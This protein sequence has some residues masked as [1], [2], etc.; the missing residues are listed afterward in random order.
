MFRCFLTGLFA[1]FVL[2]SNSSMNAGELK[3]KQR[4]HISIIGNTLPERMQHD[5]W[6]ETLIHNRFPEKQLTIR[7][8]AFSGDTLSIRLRSAGFGS[9]DEWLTNTKTDIVFAFFGFN[10]SFNGS[11][12]L[13][14]FQKELDEF[15]SHTLGQKYNGVSAPQLVLISPIAHEQLDDPSL[16]DAKINNR[17]LKLYTAAM[18]EIAVKREIPFVDL[19]SHSQ[20]AYR[21]SDKPLTINGVHLTSAGNQILAPKIDAALFGERTETIGWPVL[22]PLRQSVLDKN[23]FWF[24]RYRTTDGYSAYGGRSYLK[25]VEG[26]TNREV[27]M[28]ELQVLDEMTANR[29]KQIWASAQGKDDKVNDDNLSPFLPVESNKPGS[30]PTGKHIIL[31][32]EKAIDLMTVH[33]GMKV[34]L[35]ADEKMFPELINPVQ[36]AVDMKGRLWVAVWPT[37]PHW[38]PD[39]EMNDKLL[40]L[41]DTSQDG[42]ADKC[43]TFADHLHN[44]T[45]FEFWNG[46]VLV[47]QAPDLMF[48]KDTDGDDVA[49]VRQRVLH[50][51]D[52]A[53]T[54]HTANSFVFGPGGNLY[55]QE[56]VFHRTQTETPYG[57]QRNYDACVWRYNPRRQDF[58]RYIPYGFANP[59]GHVFDAW[60]QGI[61]HDGTSASPYHDTLISGYLPFPQKHGRAPN[62]YRQRTR[63]CSATEILSSSHFPDEFQGNLLVGN[64]IGLQGILQYKL[65]PNGSSIGAEE[66]TPI[67]SSSDPNFRPSDIE[68]GSD[69]AIYFLD[70]HNPLIGH[71]QHNLR[72]PSRDKQH[73]RVYR[74]T[75]EGR[76]LSVNEPLDE[77]SIIELLEKLKSPEDRVRYRTRLELS[78][79][80]T[81]DVMAAIRTWMPRLQKNEPGYEHDLLEV[82]WVHQHHQVINKNLLEMLLVADDSRA[83]AAAIKVLTEWRDRIPA[84]LDLI[85]NAATDSEPRVRL[86]A[87]RAASYF[88]QPSA[89]EIVLIAAELS[90]DEFLDYTKAE[91]MKVLE[92]QWEQAV[93]NGEKVEFTSAAGRRYWLGK[94][95]TTELLTMDR[96]AAVL[97]ELLYREGVSDPIRRGAIDALAKLEG[98]S[99]LQMLLTTIEN[100]DKTARS[101]SIVYDMVRILTG[102]T[103]TELQQVRVR[104]I[105]MARAGGYPIVRQIGYVALISADGNS[106]AAWEIA[107]SSVSSSKDFLSAMPLILDP[108]VQDR[109]YP[110]VKELLISPSEEIRSHAMTAMVSVPGREKENFDTLAPFVL[111][112]KD[113]LA[114]MR[115]IQRIPREDWSPDLVPKLADSVLAYLKSTQE[116]ERRTPT[117]I[118][119]LQFGEMLSTMLPTAD[120]KRVQQALGELGVQVVRLATL[121]HRMS[122]DQERI[123]VQAGKTVEMIFSN[124]D[125]MPHNFAITQAGALEEV[126][127]L[128]EANAQKPEFAANGFIPQSDKILVASRLLQPRESQTFSFKV[129][130]KPGV[131]PYVCTYPGHWRRMYGALYVVEN[132]QKYLTDPES[133]LKTHPL[134]IQDDLLKFSRPRKEWTLDELT[135]SIED[136]HG[137]SYRSARQIFTIANCIGC[138]KLNGVG[139]EF[140]P[141]LSKLDPKWTPEEVLRHMLEPSWKINEKY[142]SYT[143]VTNDGQIITGLLVKETKDEI[144]LAE[145]PLAKTPLKSIKAASIV[146]KKKSPVSLMPKGLLDRLRREEILDLL[147]Y[148]LAGGKEDHM[149]FH[150]HHR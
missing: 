127:L 113:R 130:D 83:R 1:S 140:G 18:R 20:E 92:P 23:F 141:D 19:F 121:P 65:Q 126:G 33:P 139:Q 26:Q 57:P 91:S 102:W 8:L 68:I 46:G 131:Y 136:L 2:L 99:S 133:Y 109:L 28:R 42:V 93:A 98:V 52:S 106:D 142:Q 144:T 116:A 97:E 71:M 115:A 63:P 51:L 54:H 21:Q 12:G 59:H 78:K 117:A 55:F 119:A 132:R 32:G 15:I 120:A 27:I 47:A 64:V 37:Y 118:E 90:T 36:T 4:D 72:D 66:L 124:P 45:G 16:P 58:E 24:H 13:D 17:N 69:G 85:K 143:F 128:A 107:S 149:L 3:L 43:I 7:N 11:A 14:Q 5:G 84:A 147:A 62:V 108:A 110:R 94:I 148:V 25:F 34:N 96:D 87:I 100:L 123:I 114:A 38:R 150:H 137:R 39:G 101:E 53:D 111:R 89:L 6:L 79:R 44:P 40:I 22:E 112:D 61:V 70:W 10:E 129:P 60:G 125:L 86:E 103:P 31:D 30:G 95:S 74:V 76:D 49:D 41:E 122:Y 104:L 146:E 82:L 88:T 138:H 134:D 105:N 35:F 135:A 145:N 77:L 80:P 67:V 75:Y 29:D 56:G 81:V 48:L 9:P 50:G 73:G